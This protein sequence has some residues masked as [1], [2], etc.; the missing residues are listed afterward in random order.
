[1]EDI[2]T[3]TAAKMF[4]KL[5]EDITPEERRKAKEYNFADLYS[6]TFTFEE[7]LKFQYPTT[8]ED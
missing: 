3:Q 8:K 6:T 1:M 5:P 7:W 2:H 4:N